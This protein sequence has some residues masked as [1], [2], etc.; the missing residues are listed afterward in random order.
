MRFKN[1]Y[2]S[3]TSF[4]L[5]DILRWQI[6]KKRA[7]TKEQS[8]LKTVHTPQALQSKKD[9]ICWLGHASFLIQLNEKRFL[10]DPVFGDIPLYKRYLPTPYT[11]QE[12]G[13]ID[14][15]LL[16]HVHYD[17]FDTPTI[18][19]LLEKNPTFLVPKGMDIYLK[20]IDKNISIHMFDWYENHQTSK[21]TFVDLVPAKHWGRRGLF[22]TNRS[23]WGG[24]VLRDKQHTLYFAGD[25][26]YDT[27]FEV[28]A[29]HY[30]IDYALLPVGA[31]L[32]ESVMKNNHLNPDEAYQ[33]FRELQADTL[34]PMHYGTFKLTYEP[35]NEPLEWIDKL[36]EKHTDEIE[37]IGI[38]EVRFL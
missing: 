24:F 13:E 27:H 2:D 26:A 15:V 38:G 5:R 22:D 37:I 6:T 25:T 23:L 7:T 32:P 12:L 19:A 21:E 10:C 9:F 28:I 4:R 20:K 35:I 3:T 17:H 30:N 36:Y 34:I 8:H 14:Y 29:Q 16:S 11:T 1:R 31:Y 18:R 33:A